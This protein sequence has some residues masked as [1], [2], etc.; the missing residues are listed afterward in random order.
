MK[1]LSK[2]DKRVILFIIF[3][4]IFAFLLILTH[5][6]N[7][8]KSKILKGSVNIDY[9]LL[10]YE[11]NEYEQLINSLQNKYD[12]NEIVGLI[13]IPNTNIYEIVVQGDD[14]E[15]YLNHN[16]NKKKDIKGAVFLDYRV[17]EDSLKKLI[18][19]HNSSTLDV[20]FRELEDYYDYEYYLTHKYIY[21]V[22][23][24]GIKKYEIFSTFVETSD[25]SYMKIDF[26]DEDIWYKHIKELKEK[27]MYET[28]VNLTKKD[29]VLILQTCSHHEDFKKYKNKYLII[30]ARGN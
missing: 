28:N 23:K 6:N 19:S 10:S 2:V 15:F 8:N 27:S 11:T 29:S 18:Y 26:N 16:I 30:V 4:V 3:I 12:N 13:I 17:E 14:N 1:K 7:Y 25:W 22:S 20:P 9:D 21:Y 5:D 24:S